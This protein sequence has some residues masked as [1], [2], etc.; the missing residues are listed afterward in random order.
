[1]PKMKR[2]KVT[3]IK[4]EEYYIYANSMA[5]AETAAFNIQGEAENID[6]YDEVI[7]SEDER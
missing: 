3:L 5:S 6:F 1:M 4:K 2:Y 7:I